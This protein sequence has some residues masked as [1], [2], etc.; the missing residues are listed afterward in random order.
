MMTLPY[1]TG[2]A[3]AYD[4]LSGRWSNLYLGAVLGQLEP[5]GGRR[6]LD[7][8]TG[9]A[10]CA[11]AAAKLID[12]GLVVGA[13]FSLPMLR[14]GLHKLGNARISLVAAD[15]HHLPFKADHFD[16]ATCL[17]GLM[18]FEDP[19]VALKEAFRVLVPGGKL[20]CTT[21]ATTDRVP[22]GGVMAEVLAAEAPHLASELLRP[23][24]MAD[25]DLSLI[26][27]SEPTRP[28]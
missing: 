13:D 7:L 17:F 24:S 9:T 28:Y 16:G 12:R 3:A 27:I 26:H 6:L 14:G 8:A 4:C 19:V 5:L 20:I 11:V 25:P 1:D 18:F 2:A 10:E 15:A 23:Y 22:W 21:W